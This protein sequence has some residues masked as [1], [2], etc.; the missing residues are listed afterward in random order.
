MKNKILVSSV[1][2]IGML[3]GCATSS[4]NNAAIEATAQLAVVSGA[5]IFTSQEVTS[6]P[7]YAPDFLIGEQVLSE[8]DGSTTQITSAEVDQLMAQ[9][10][11]TNPVVNIVVAN[12]LQAANV[13]ISTLT[14]S[15][16]GVQNEDLQT[17][18]FWISSGIS[19]GLTVNSSKIQQEY[20]TVNS[21]Q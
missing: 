2:A 3:V 5:A 17:V 6:H 19:E 1:L 15:T 9:A 16:P 11:E 4:N 18:C 21:K 7:Q 14:N 13:W 10:G 20:N 12:G 8:L